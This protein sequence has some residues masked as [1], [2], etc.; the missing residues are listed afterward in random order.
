MKAYKAAKEAADG[1]RAINA[2]LREATLV[3]LGVAER[4]VKVAEIANDLKPIS[5]PNMKSDLVTAIALARAALEGAL[6][7]VAINLDSIQ[8]GSPE[9]ESFVAATRE[10][11]SGLKIGA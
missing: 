2:A 10:R 3:P 1:G 9:D 5:N 4:A 7:N 8:P 11:A 6:A